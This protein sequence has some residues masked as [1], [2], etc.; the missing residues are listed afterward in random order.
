MTWNYR[1]WKDETEEG[2]VFSIKETFYNADG[3]IWACSSEAST[4]FGENLEEFKRDLKNF[5]K[6]IDQPVLIFKGFKFSTND[7]LRDDL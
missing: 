3:G 6:A 7:N 1:V 4:P 2:D 5:A